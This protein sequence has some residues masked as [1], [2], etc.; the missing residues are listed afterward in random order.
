MVDELP[1]AG[2]VVVLPSARLQAKR[3]IWRKFGKSERLL[4]LFD[5]LNRRGTHEDVN[6]KDATNRTKRSRRKGCQIELG[7]IGVVEDNHVA[8]AVR[9]NVQVHRELA[10]GVELFLFLRKILQ[11]NGHHS[12]QAGWSSLLWS[13]LD[14]SERLIEARI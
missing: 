2:R 12:G 7:R 9:L 10:V 6:V 5:R 3:P 13:R 14:G 11:V 4:E 8:V 1:Q